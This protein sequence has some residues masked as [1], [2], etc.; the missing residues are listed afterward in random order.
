[1]L[2]KNFT[3]PIPLTKKCH[4]AT[5]IKCIYARCGQLQF[6]GPLTFPCAQGV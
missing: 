3:S 2:Q 5:D 4:K 1:M 6:G